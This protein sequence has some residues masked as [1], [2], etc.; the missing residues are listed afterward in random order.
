MKCYRLLLLSKIGH[1]LKVIIYEFLS[2][3]FLK[4]KK[5][6]VKQIQI[7]I[8][9]YIILV[10]PP[11]NALFDIFLAGLHERFIANKQF[12]KKQYYTYELQIIVLF[13]LFI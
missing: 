13:Y 11:N 1:G 6:G 12:K 5:N 8:F 9:E 3:S 7:A 4:N 2:S 10:L